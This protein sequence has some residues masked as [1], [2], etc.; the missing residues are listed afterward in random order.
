MR[1]ILS[2]LTVFVAAA[3]LPVSDAVARP[4]STPKL[5]VAATSPL[6]VV[7][8]GFEPREIVRV[9]VRTDEGDTAKSATA[10]ATGQITMR[11]AR[12]KLERCADVAVV[13]HGN[14]GSRVGLH[15]PPA[16]CGIDPRAG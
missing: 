12:L 15:R 16:A 3:L 13:A 7:G 5:V 10:S 6:V 11:F 9:I 8:T 4:A 2:A 1:R 14:K